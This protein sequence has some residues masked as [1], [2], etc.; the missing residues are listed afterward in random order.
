MGWL[1]IAKVGLGL[2]GLS[3][4]KKANKQAKQAQEAAAEQAAAQL[5]LQKE[6]MAA[7]EK[8]RKRYR[9]F[10]FTN[11]YAGLENPY[12]DIT[13]NQ[14][15]A[16]FQL[17]QAAQ[18][19]ANIMQGLSGAAGA[20]GIAS[21][22]QALAAQ[23]TLQTR[24]VSVDIAKQEA[25]NQRLRAQGDSAREM[26]IRGGE[27]MVQ[28]AEMRRQATLLGVAYQGAAGAAAGVQAAYA[29]QMSA[30]ATSAQMAGSTASSAFNVLGDII[31]MPDT[32]F[33]KEGE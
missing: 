33:K 21:L 9:E 27:Q 26:A 30:A 20:S 16:E 29:N 31:D 24:Q 3:Q 10:Q 1:A 12:E 15:A 8:Q 25:M 7:L 28:E 18:Q 5:A 19:R 2:L 22:A 14:Q 11:P 6:Q 13:V 17:E 32:P 23:G 4:S